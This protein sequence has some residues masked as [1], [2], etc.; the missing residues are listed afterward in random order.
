MIEEIKS[1]LGRQNLFCRLKEVGREKPNDAG[2][3]NWITGGP[4]IIFTL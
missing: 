1:L 2:V 3:E 4:P